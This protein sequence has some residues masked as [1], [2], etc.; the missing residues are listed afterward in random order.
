M[1]A[2]RAT[3]LRWEENRT[4]LRRG[5]PEPPA[6]RAEVTG[7]SSGG[8]GRTRPVSASGAKSCSPGTPPARP[9]PPT[10]STLPSSRGPCLRLWSGPSA[11]LAAPPRLLGILP[12]SA[13]P[14]PTPACQVSGGDRTVTGSGEVR[15]LSAA[16]PA[17]LQALTAQQQEDSR[18]VLK[19]DH[20]SSPVTC[21][22]RLVSFAVKPRPGLQ[23]P[24]DQPLCRSPLPNQPSF[25]CSPRPHWP[26]AVAATHQP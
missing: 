5:R 17:P 2:R 12:D 4:A 13:P 9:P 6:A 7:L 14:P 25:G 10:L 24:R 22:Q 26:P 18:S 11:H 21:V 8:R 3:A 15:A 23:G 1:I 20:G 19:S 16:S